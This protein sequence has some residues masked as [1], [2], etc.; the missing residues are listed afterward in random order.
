MGMP[1]DQGPPG[2]HVIEISVSV[3][4]L[5]H[6][7]LPAFHEN[8]LVSYGTKGPDRGIYASWEIS[9]GFCE[10]LSGFFTFHVSFP[11]FGSRLIVFFL[12]KG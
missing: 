5:D 1:Q 9:P 7:P 12:G 4:I 3:Q 6:G 10:C 2:T 11:C 8:R